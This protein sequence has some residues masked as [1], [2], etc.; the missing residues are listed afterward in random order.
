VPC[1]GAVIRDDAGRLLLVR[2]GHAPGLGLWS[3]PGG[4][5]E[6]GETDAQALIRE[7]REETGL[8]VEPTA[9]LGSVE[10]PAADDGTFLIRDYAAVVTGGSLAAGDDAADVRW[11]SVEE[12]ASLPLTPGLIEALTSWAAL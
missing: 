9:L 8:K 2:R 1:V 4:R 3:L 10:R 11:V 5:V 6:A 7:L 12:L